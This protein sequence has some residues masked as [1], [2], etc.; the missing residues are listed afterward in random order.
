MLRRSSGSASATALVI[1]GE[2]S[3]A[4]L[5]HIWAARMAFRLN[6]RVREWRHMA[7]RIRAGN[8]INADYADCAI[9]VTDYA[10]GGADYADTFSIVRQTSHQH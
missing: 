6:H 5:R 10:D 3:H 7:A 8:T 2:H 4:T 9:G 1:A